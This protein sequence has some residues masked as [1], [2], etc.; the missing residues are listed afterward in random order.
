[1][2]TRTYVATFWP[3]DP[4]SGAEMQEMYNKLR[5]AELAYSQEYSTTEN[6]TTPDDSTTEDFGMED[7]RPKDSALEDIAE[8]DSW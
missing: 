8:D 3:L 4:S 1:M 5:K 7:S 6:S 2:I